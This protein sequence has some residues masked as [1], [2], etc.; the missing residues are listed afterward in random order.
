MK[1]AL[2]GVLMV[3]LLIPVVVLAGES[4]RI[5]V[6]ANGKTSDASVSNKT[7]QSP[8]FLIYDEQ[9][10]IVAAVDN[11]FQNTRSRPTGSMIESLTFD[12]KGALTGGGITTPSR[13]DRAKIWD[14]IFSFFA[15]WRIKVI[16]AEEFGDEVLRAFKAHGISCVAF[17]GRADEALK[18]ALQSAK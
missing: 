2:L 6:A 8:F 13:D 10:K 7:G 14:A 12:D 17:K 16:V 5:A 18:K 1:K 15:Q 11:P 9:G 4:G 3:S